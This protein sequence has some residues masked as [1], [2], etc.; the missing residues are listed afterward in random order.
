VRAQEIV[1][2]LSKRFGFDL[3][4]TFG[5]VVMRFVE[6]RFGFNFSLDP[7]DTQFIDRVAALD[8]ERSAAGAFP[9]SNMFAT[10]NTCRSCRATVSCM[11]GPCRSTG[12]SFGFLRER[13]SESQYVN[14]FTLH[15]C[16]RRGMVNQ[17][18]DGVAGFWDISNFFIL[19]RSTWGREGARPQ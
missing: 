9:G 6:R 4:L 19:R 5:A 10:Y 15:A 13:R 17:S 12:R 11:L 3:F 18:R 16:A 2:A 1:E 14:A 8:E 7:E